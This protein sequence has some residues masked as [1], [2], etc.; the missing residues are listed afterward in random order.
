VLS[1]AD[2]LS[3]LRDIQAAIELGS[4]SALERILDQIDPIVE[5]L[6]DREREVESLPF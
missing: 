6:E 1:D 5:T 2:L 3:L 4:M